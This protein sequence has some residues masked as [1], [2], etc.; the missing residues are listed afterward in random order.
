AARDADR[1]CAGRPHVDGRR[2]HG[3]GGT[4]VRRGTRERGARQPVFL[5]ADHRGIV[6]ALL[7]T[8]PTILVLWPVRFVLALFQQPTELVDLAT[9]YVR[10]SIVGVLP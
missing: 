9:S 6:L 3:D 1:A 5:H 7:L 10:I 2:G 4:R 8:A